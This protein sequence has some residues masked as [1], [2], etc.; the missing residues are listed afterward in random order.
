MSAPPSLLVPVRHLFPGSLFFF[1]TNRIFTISSQ[2]TRPLPLDWGDSSII[3]LALLHAKCQIFSL[4]ENDIR[5][6]GQ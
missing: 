4:K 3:Y 6:L 1:T 5:M 2:K